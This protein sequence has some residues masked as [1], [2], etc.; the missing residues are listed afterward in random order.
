MEC[1]VE[2]KTETEEKSFNQNVLFSVEI[3]LQHSKKMFLCQKRKKRKKNT[4]Y[5]CFLKLKFKFKK[6]YTNFQILVSSFDL[7]C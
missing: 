7:D 2:K 5:F 3:N 4:N 6:C 1:L